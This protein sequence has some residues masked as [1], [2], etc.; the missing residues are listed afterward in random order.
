MGLST[1]PAKGRSV[2][3]HN[4][5]VERAER[6]QHVECKFLHSLVLL[7]RAKHAGASKIHLDGAGC[8]PGRLKPVWQSDSGW[9]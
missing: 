8:S 1:D 6:G 4:T 3:Y 5:G 9:V 2:P 7:S